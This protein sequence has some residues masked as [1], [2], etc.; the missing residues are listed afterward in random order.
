MKPY[1]WAG[2]KLDELNIY[3]KTITTFR[4]FDGKIYESEKAEK[5][6]KLKKTKE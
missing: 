6:L 3:G 5:P 4:L 2:R 1:L